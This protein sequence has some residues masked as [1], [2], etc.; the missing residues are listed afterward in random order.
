MPI[1]PHATQP[2]DRRNAGRGAQ[3]PGELRILL[4][5]DSRLLRDRLIGMLTV[6]GILRIAGTAE[7]EQEAIDLIDAHDYDALVVDVEL[8]Q[9]SGIAAIRHARRSFATRTQPLI[10][11][12]TNYALPTVEQRCLGA[13][14][15]HFLDKMQQFAEVRPLLER[16]QRGRGH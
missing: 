11:V 6:P 4:I 10:I 2:K 9:G 3:A 13:G 12:L 14:A 7:T 8:K 15:D 5:E 1:E 16:H